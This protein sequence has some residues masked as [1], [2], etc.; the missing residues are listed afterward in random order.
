MVTKPRP[1][2]PLSALA[3]NRPHTHTHHHLTGNH[4]IP[5]QT[6]VTELYP[7]TPSAARVLSSGPSPL[8]KSAGG[9]R[10]PHRSTHLYGDGGLLASSSLR[11]SSMGDRMSVTLNGVECC[12]CSADKFCCSRADFGDRLIASSAALSSGS[13]S[14]GHGE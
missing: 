3:H 10:P 6:N 12:R 4:N 7:S 1:V 14:A 2:I 13:A 9:G 5:A 11:Y 8:E